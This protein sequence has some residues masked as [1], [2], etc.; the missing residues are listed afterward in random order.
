LQQGTLTLIPIA[1]PQAF[2][3]NR[4]YIDCNLNRN[5]RY[6]AQ[7]QHYEHLLANTI[8]PYIKQAD[9]IVD[10][11]STTAVGESNVFQDYLTPDNTELA[12][13]TG[14]TWIIQ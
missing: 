9:I 14:Q 12:Q 1:N 13:A 2:K 6:H 5:F 8:I 7:P 3:Q 4:T 10:L 11:H